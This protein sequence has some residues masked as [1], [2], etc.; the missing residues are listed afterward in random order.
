M[1]NF[2][3]PMPPALERLEKDIRL[4]HGATAGL[5]LMLRRAEELD[6]ESIKNALPFVELIWLYGSGIRDLLNAKRPDGTMLWNAP[7][8]ASL[9]RPLQ[10][11]FLSLVYFAIETP[12]AEE[13]EFRRMLLGRHAI[14]KRWDLL[15]RADQSNKSISQ[16]CAS[17]YTEWESIQHEVCSHS[18]MKKLPTEMAR[19]VSKDGDHYFLSPL[20]EIWERAGLPK[21]LYGVTFR[22]LSQYAH[23]TPYAVANLKFHQA[24]HEN[25]AVNMTVPIGLALTC[26]T[27]TIQ[28]FSQLHFVLD[29]LVPA[30]FRKYM[31]NSGFAD[32]ADGEK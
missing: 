5:E 7:A 23:A 18:F 9:C 19:K 4:L 24:G 12:G 11:A 32:T 8:L 10:E 6:Q 2:D 15:R 3:N 27:L 1:N 17:A 14:Y 16:E 30:A 21:E 20:D 26:I 31:G 13:A 25:G 22:Y 29:A 28:L